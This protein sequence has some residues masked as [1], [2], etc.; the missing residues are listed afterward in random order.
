[1][2]ASLPVHSRD[3]AASGG[4]AA[5]LLCAVVLAGCFL[6]EEN[7]DD[8]IVAARRES[9][10]ALRDATRRRR[11]DAWFLVKVW[12]R[13]T[14][15]EPAAAADAAAPDGDAE[16]R[17]AA[18]S[19]S[20]A[21][22]AEPAGQAESILLREGRPGFLAFTRAGKVE[23]IRIGNRLYTSDAPGALGLEAVAR[24]EGRG[25]VSLVLTPIFLGLGEAGADV[26]APA[27]ASRLAIDSGAVAAVRPRPGADPVVLAL[28]RDA[29]GQGPDARPVAREVWIGAEVFR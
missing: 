5:I 18:E 14:P 9:E 3:R 23:R 20:F 19:L 29:P 10:T 6:L 27:L 13:E 4:A 11:S 21:V 22:P 26:C 25:K 12:V 1:M 8:P 16:D 17:G 7:P 28:F 24:D 2:S 15:S